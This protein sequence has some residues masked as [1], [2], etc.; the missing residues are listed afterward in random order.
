MYMYV[1]SKVTIIEM[2][3]MT[4]TVS[5]SGLCLVTGPCSS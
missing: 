5:L 1:L 4:N 2:V 3:K